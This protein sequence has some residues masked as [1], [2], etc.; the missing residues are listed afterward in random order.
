MDPY[1][2]YDG[3]LR[4]LTVVPITRSVLRNKE[5]FLLDVCSLSKCGRILRVAEPEITPLFL[6]RDL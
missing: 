6:C 5:H 4:S 3:P 2:S 1:D